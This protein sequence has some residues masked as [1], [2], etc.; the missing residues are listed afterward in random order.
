MAVSSEKHG[1][2]VCGNGIR[3]KGN[4]PQDAYTQISQLLATTKQREFHDI[5]PAEVSA[6]D[7]VLDSVRKNRICE[8]SQDFKNKHFAALG[9]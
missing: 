7:N 3:P 9:V 4:M 8:Y 5:F 1:I 2:V 6:V